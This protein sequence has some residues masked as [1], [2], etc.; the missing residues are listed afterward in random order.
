MKKITILLKAIFITLLF[1]CSTNF[2]GQIDTPI[3][4]DNCELHIEGGTNHASDDNDVGVISSSS[5]IMNFWL[6]YKSD[7]LYLS[8]ERGGSG[9]SSFTFYFNTDCKGGVDQEGFGDSSYGDQGRDGADWVAFFKLSGNGSISDNKLYKYNG[10]G[11]IDSGK[12]FI[13][14]VGESICSDS[15]TEGQFFEME[16]SI[17]DILFDVCDCGTIDLT[18]GESNAGVF[19]SDVKDLFDP[20]NFNIE[21]NYAEASNNGPVCEGENIELFSILTSGI[22]AT[23]YW[24]GPK[25][26]TSDVKNPTFTAN[27]LSDGT[28]I[29]TITDDEGCEHVA[30]TTVTVN[31]LPTVT[32]GSYGPVCVDANDVTLIGDPIGGVWS[33]K[34]VSGSQQSG[35][36]FDPSQGTQ[37]ITYTYTD[38]NTCINSNTTQIT[39]NPL[40]TATISYAGSP[41][42]AVG[43]ASVTQTG[44]SDGIYSSTAGLSIN[45]TTGVINLVS[46]TIGIHTVTYSFTDNNT[47]SN[48]TTTSITIDALPTATISYAG[49]PYCAVG[50]ASVTQSGQSDGT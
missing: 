36:V 41:Y 1:L 25:G 42:C 49:S 21:I 26:F 45:S 33:G 44:E 3:D 19:G 10:L 30:T 43:T 39:V 22:P 47:C 16:I 2:Y 24:T 35:Y 48:T 13:A 5:D 18:E 34:G 14:M 27:T 4:G 46:S 38:G 20:N 23:I 31:P 40:P 28:Y 37:T 8:F 6:D 7:Y 50:T 17:E 15:T 9:T 12:T 29:V 11:Y 32:P